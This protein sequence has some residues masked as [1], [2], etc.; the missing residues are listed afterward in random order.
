MPIVAQEYEVGENTSTKNGNAVKVVGTVYGISTVKTGMTFIKVQSK[1]G[2]KVNV[3]SYPGM[4]NL[5]S[6]KKGDMIEVRGVLDHYQGDL[7]VF[8]YS[9]KEF[10]KYETAEIPIR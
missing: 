3:V 6:L 10:R 4:G 9:S 7:Q 2:L 8:P 1:D 5:L